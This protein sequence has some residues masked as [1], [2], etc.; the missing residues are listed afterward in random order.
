MPRDQATRVEDQ[1]ALLACRSDRP[2]R[3]RE[4]LR[5]ERLLGVATRTRELAAHAR[6]RDDRADLGHRPGLRLRGRV[7]AREHHQR[8][9]PAPHLRDL[10][11]RNG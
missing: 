9:C 3:A 2:R 6:G 11:A 5:F 8:R 10:T 4:R 1:R 7:P